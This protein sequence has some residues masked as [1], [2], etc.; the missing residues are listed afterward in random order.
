MGRYNTAV[1]VICGV[2]HRAEIR[3]IFVL[4]YYY[5][6]SGMLSGSTFYSDKTERKAVFICRIVTAL[7]CDGIKSNIAA[8]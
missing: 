5:K 3:Y 2:L 8:K 7:S 1:R 6:A 4:R